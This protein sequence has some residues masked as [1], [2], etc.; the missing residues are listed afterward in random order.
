MRHYRSA[1][2]FPLSFITRLSHFSISRRDDD[3]APQLICDRQLPFV[4]GC[5]EH[6][7]ISA[8]GCAPRSYG[9]SL[10]LISASLASLAW[11]TSLEENADNYEH[12]VCW[13][14]QDI[15]NIDKRLMCCMM[16]LLILIFPR[17]FISGN[18]STPL[19]I[20]SFSFRAL[21]QTMGSRIFW[22]RCKNATAMPKFLHGFHA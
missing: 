1:V 16:M 21:I 6:G 4:S 7:E 20:L 14:Y 3:Y 8:V 15:F 22:L 9:A 5:I 13:R 19:I 17:I 10:S 2:P 18:M 11:R 12:I